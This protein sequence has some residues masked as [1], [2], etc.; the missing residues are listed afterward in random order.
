MSCIAR[1]SRWFPFVLLFVSHRRWRFRVVF[2]SSVVSRAKTRR[3]LFFCSL[4]LV[5]FGLLCRRT[6]IASQTTQKPGTSN[7]MQQNARQINCVQK[8]RENKNDG[9]ELQSSEAILCKSTNETSRQRPQQSRS[10]FSFVAF[11][12]LHFD[13]ATFSVW[14]LVQTTFRLQTIEIINR[15]ERD[16]TQNTLKRRANFDEEEKNVKKSS[17]CDWK[18]RSTAGRMNVR[19]CEFNRLYVDFVCAEVGNKQSNDDEEADDGEWQR[20]L[21]LLLPIICR[22]FSLSASLFTSLVNRRLFIVHKYLCATRDDWKAMRNE[23]HKIQF[24]VCSVFSVN[25]R[26]ICTEQTIF[27]ATQWSSGRT[28]KPRDFFRSLSFA[29]FRCFNLETVNTLSPVFS[30]FLFCH[31]FTSRTN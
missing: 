4:S 8:E 15:R 22:S 14:P 6:R 3:Q 7:A 16:E 30:L 28:T 17:R 23:S 12:A 18:D 31:L 26:E 19:E 11:F 24:V 27:I 21:M 9:K 13:E 5:V 29:S 25:T 20:R 2:H 1:N 10:L